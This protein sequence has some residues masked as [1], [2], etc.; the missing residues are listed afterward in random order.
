MTQAGAA[1]WAAPAFCDR[2]PGDHFSFSVP[3]A[4]AER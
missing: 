2:L 1:L 4:W 3:L